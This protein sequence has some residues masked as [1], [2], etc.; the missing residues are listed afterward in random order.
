MDID[1]N[2]MNP[3]QRSTELSKKALEYLKKY[4]VA[5][6]PKSYDVWY[7]YASGENVE[8]NKAIGDFIEKGGIPDQVFTDRIHANILSYEVIAKTVDSVTGLL[9]D[10]IS[11]V[12][13]AMSGTDEELSVFSDLLVGASSDIK[14]GTFDDMVADKLNSAVDK[15]NM[16]VKELEANLEVSHGEIKKLQHY[17]ETV[18][19]EANVDPLTGLATRKRY[20]QSLSQAVRNSIEANEDMC[21]VF[22]EIDHYDAFRTKWGQ[23]TAEQILRFVATAIRENIKGRD[24]SARYSGSCFALI[25][26]K[27]S[28]DGS[29]TLSDHIRS[30][31]ERKRI[32]KKTTGEFLGRVTLSVGIAKYAH[33]ESIGFFCNRC[34][35]SLLAARANGRNCTITELEAED[36][37]SGITSSVQDSD[38]SSDNGEAGAA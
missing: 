5:P 27:T 33:G 24:V 30:T 38:L 16:R 8:V 36:V 29:R 10:Q 4:N 28:I 11:G 21:I 23:T 22:L 32:V 13:G 18:R 34:D 20:D 3:M 2:E 6:D 9:T 14:H 37:L 26:P 25:L 17:L 31:V 15:V 12:A 7:Q 19:Q 35:R 1:N